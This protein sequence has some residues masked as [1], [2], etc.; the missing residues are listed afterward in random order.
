MNY[1]DC[2]GQETMTNTPF[3][4][5]D[6]VVFNQGTSA[7]CLTSNNLN[8]EKENSFSLTLDHSLTSS[9]CSYDLSSNDSAYASDSHS[10][11][12]YPLFLNSPSSQ[13]SSPSNNDLQSAEKAKNRRPKTISYLESRKEIEYFQH[14]KRGRPRQD[15]KIY[16]VE[17]GQARAENNQDKLKIARNKKS[18]QV[19]RTN[20]KNEMISTEEELKMLLN[21]NSKLTRKLQT[22]LTVNQKFIGL[23]QVSNFN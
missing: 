19:Y 15:S 8:A 4:M 14:S 11:S 23:S 7:N 9:K 22:Y 1:S 17:I 20:K 13:S 18:S 3:R 10:E 12:Q 2:Y 21:I 5:E 16:D 6:F